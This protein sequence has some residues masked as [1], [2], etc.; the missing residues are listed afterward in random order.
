[1][2]GTQGPAADVDEDPLGLE[3]VVADADAVRAFEPGMAAEA[4]CNAPCPRSQFSL[5]V[6]AVAR[7]LLRAGMHARHVDADWSP[8]STPKSA[9]RRARWAA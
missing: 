4:A 6:A 1:M 9:A 5:P 3:D 7:D 2:S 8:V